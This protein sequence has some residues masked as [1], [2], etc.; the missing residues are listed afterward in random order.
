[1]V[2]LRKE[3]PVM[4]YG[5]GE[6]DDGEFFDWGWV[7]DCRT[8]EVIWAMDAKHAVWAGGAGKNRMCEAGAQLGPGEYAVTYVTDDSHSAGGGWN[9]SPPWDADHAGMTL[10]WTGAEAEPGNY[11]SYARERSPGLLGMIAAVGDRA[12]ETVPFE[13]RRP[14]TVR[15]VCQGE[16]F[17]SEMYDFGW[18]EKEGD[19]ERV[20]TMNF[21]I[22]NH[23]GGAKKNRE[24]RGDIQL[25][26]GTYRLRYVSDDSHSFN[27]W[28]AAPPS[29][30]GADWGISVYRLR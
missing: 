28:N 19:G 2:R 25:P 21:D 7:K 4:F 22:S 12:N 5:I 1:M 30:R 20:W 26:A 6:S 3:G 10:Y 9:A 27:D 13:L 8:G 24:W 15:V 23:A 11:V 29:H 16:G 18:I 17:Q 14:S